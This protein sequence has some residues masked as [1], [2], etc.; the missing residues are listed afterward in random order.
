MQGAPHIRRE[1]RNR[2]EIEALAGMAFAFLM[3]VTLALTIGGVILLKPLMKNLG[4]Y[5]EAKA[6]ERRGIG[7]PSSEDWN[8]LFTTMENLGQRMETLEERQDFT[9]KLLSKPDG[10]GGEA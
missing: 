7:G 3:T 6:D 5:L 2:M 1:E 9:E 10:K 4:D 8:R